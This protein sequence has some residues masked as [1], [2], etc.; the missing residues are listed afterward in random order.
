[1]RRWALEAAGQLGGKGAIDTRHLQITGW[2]RET[3]VADLRVGR[4]LPESDR[5]LPPAGPSLTGGAETMQHRAEVAA[6][7][8]ARLAAQLGLW[9]AHISSSQSA[10]GMLWAEAAHAAQSGPWPLP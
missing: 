7:A 8:A 5:N 9:R 3:I 6:S 4:N 2:N 1:M 10:N